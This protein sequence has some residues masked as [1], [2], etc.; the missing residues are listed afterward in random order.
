MNAHVIVG[1]GTPVA[2]QVYVTS[3]PSK[4]SSFEGVGGWMITAGIAEGERGEGGEGGVWRREEGG[5]E[6]G[7]RR[8]EGEGEEGGERGRREEMEEEGEE[9]EEG[10]DERGRTRLW[11][12]QDNS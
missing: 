10:E 6:G 3:A 9:R 5:G 8:E 1:R 2:V 4:T 11:D 12:G 7:G